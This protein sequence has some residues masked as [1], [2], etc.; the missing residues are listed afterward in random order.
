MTIHDYKV[1]CDE[2]NNSKE[3]IDQGK[4]TVDIT[5]P[6]YLLDDEED[7]QLD[8]YEIQQYKRRLRERKDED[9]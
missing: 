8:D 6:L 4:F 9:S 5:I 3:L 7:D 1:V 2:S